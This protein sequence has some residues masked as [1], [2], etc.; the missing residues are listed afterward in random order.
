MA[1]GAFVAGW[2]L[3]IAARPEQRA[4]QVRREYGRGMSALEEGFEVDGL[5]DESE[6]HHDKLDAEIFGSRVHVT[7]PVFRRRSFTPRDKQP[8]LCRILDRK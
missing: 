1:H 7:S 3:G 8:P 5:V 4:V 2:L 6:K